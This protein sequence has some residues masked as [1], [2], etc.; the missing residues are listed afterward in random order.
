MRK[1]VPPDL[2]STAS[3][4]WAVRTACWTQTR[5]RAAALGIDLLPARPRGG[6]TGDAQFTVRQSAMGPAEDTGVPYSIVKHT[7]WTASRWPTEHRQPEVSWTVHRILGGIDDEQERFA[8]IKEPPT[9]RERRTPDEANRRMGRQVDNRV[10]PQEKVTAIHSL[11]R[12]DQVAAQVTAD[13]LR[14]PEVATPISAKVQR[15]GPA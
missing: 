4:R 11:A 14:R 10:S 1:S 5:S 3:H 7:R 8:A 9:G 6:D 13:P 2:P 15:A 12:D